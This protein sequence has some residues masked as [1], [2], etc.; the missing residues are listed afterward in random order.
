MRRNNKVTNANLA[1]PSILVK[2]FNVFLVV[3]IVSNLP[4]NDQ[5][6]QTIDFM[7]EYFPNETF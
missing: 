1:F 2:M 4:M 6:Y 7:N 5:F 3:E